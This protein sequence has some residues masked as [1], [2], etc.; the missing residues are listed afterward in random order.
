[1]R[2]WILMLAP[3]AALLDFVFHPG[4]LQTIGAWFGRLIQ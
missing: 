4:H 3:V 1:M 2:E